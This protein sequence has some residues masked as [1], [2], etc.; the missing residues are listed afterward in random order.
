MLVERADDGDIKVQFWRN[1][2]SAE[3][4]VPKAASDFGFGPF[5]VMA[6]HFVS[7]QSDAKKNFVR[8]ELGEVDAQLR[9]IRQAFGYS[10]YAFAPIRT[11]PRRTYDPTGAEPDPEG[12]HIPMLLARLASQSLEFL[13][14]FKRRRRES[15]L[16]RRFRNQKVVAIGVVRPFRFVA[17]Q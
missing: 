11:N 16:A 1:S 4:N 6:A 14:K 13:H 7:S 2:K 5:V 9:S 3:V 15:S 10:P 8:E 12:S 17:G